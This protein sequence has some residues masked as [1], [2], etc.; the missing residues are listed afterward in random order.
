MKVI[1][2][3]IESVVIIEPTRHEDGRGWFAEVFSQ[4]GFADK[5]C[6]KTVF[7]QDNEVWSR[8]GVVR[9][10]HFQRPPHEQAKL[11]RAVRGAIVDVAVDLRRGSP[12]FGRHVAVELSAENGRQLFIPR[13]FAHGYS[14]LGDEALVVYK[15][16]DFYA[17]DFEGGVRFD[18]SA[19]GID[20]RIDP[21]RIVVSGR[22]RALPLLSGLRI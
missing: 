9:G 12:T 5:V 22:D 11:V 18:D 15:C 7:V 1:K 2:T 19:L 13:G 21:A 17:P 10:L 4:R 6:A 3:E 16:D 8:G 20:W 14:V